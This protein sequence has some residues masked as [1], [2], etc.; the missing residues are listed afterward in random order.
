[1][2]RILFLFGFFIHFFHVEIFLFDLLEKKT[3]LSPLLE[4]NNATI[5]RDVTWSH[6][7]VSQDQSKKNSILMR[8]ENHLVRMSKPFSIFER[9]FEMS[10]FP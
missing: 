3:I 10:V 8:L 7:P 9:F 6:D 5:S 2:K 1:M 4:E